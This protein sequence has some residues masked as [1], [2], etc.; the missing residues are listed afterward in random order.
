M[1]YPTL[2]KKLKERAL[3]FEEIKMWDRVGF[4]ISTEFRRVMNSERTGYISVLTII[5][6]AGNE[7]EIDA[8]IGRNI[9][10][11]VL[12]WWQVEQVK[13]RSSEL[14]DNTGLSSLE[15]RSG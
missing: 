15:N 5:D 10:L 9:R 2:E 14:I 13:P 7:T 8:S 11:S 4:Y 3:L 6:S 12:R 1:E